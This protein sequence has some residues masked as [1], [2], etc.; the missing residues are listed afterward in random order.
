MRLTTI[1]RGAAPRAVPRRLLPAL[2]FLV[3]L[4]PPLGSLA[5]EGPGG[6]E[7]RARQPPPTPPGFT[8]PTARQI[9]FEGDNGEGYFSPDGTKIIFQSKQ[10]PEHWATQIYLLDLA[11]GQERRI[12]RNSGDDTCSYFQPSPAGEGA[13]PRRI[14]Y[15]STF[16]EIAENPRMTAFKPQARR[17]K[18]EAERQAGR[19]RG[20]SWEFLPYEVYSANLDGSEVRRLTFSPGYDAEGT[21]SPDGSKIIFTSNRDGDL[22]L[23]TMNPDGSQQRR[24]THAKGYD[25]GAF[26]SP[27][28]RS[29]VWRAFRGDGRHAQVFV[30]D[31][32]GSN[33]RQLTH[34]PAIN[35]APF[36]HPDG[37]KILYSSNRD[38]PRNFELYLIDVAAA[39]IKRL[40]YHEGA[41]ILPVF[42]PDG[43]KI[44]WT[45]NRG[46][47]NQLHL[48]DFQEPSTCLN[49]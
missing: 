30:A 39:C 32:D 31:A 19:R 42:S 37:T 16:D 7:E 46:G 9:T 34:D 15:A 22:E 41:D 36:Y 29:I 1:S 13:A 14:I 20:Y 40:T 21:F 23:Y 3:A 8:Q 43:R 11:T 38:E 2:A 27:D 48:M 33:E 45:S 10:R 28:G 18:E 44:L 12:S 26:F 47:R 49:Q 5:Q 6:G 24:I 35:W 25:G 17:A 4:P